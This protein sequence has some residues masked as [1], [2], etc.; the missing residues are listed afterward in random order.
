MTRIWSSGY[1]LKFCVKIGE[2]DSEILALL[3]LAY[4]KYV[5]KNLNVFEWHKRLKEGQEHVHGDPRSEQPKMQRTEANVDTVLTLGCSD[6][7]LDMRLI[8]E[9][10]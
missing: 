4:G 10:G 8:A 7:R 5:M 6:Q 2:S 9:E 1:I 3:T